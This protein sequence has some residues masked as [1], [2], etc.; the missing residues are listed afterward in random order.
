[1]FTFLTLSVVM[2][3]FGTI[4]SGVYIELQRKKMLCLSDEAL[5][6]AR[7][8]IKQT[9]KYIF[10]VNAGLVLFIITAGVVWVLVNSSSASANESAA[11]VTTGLKDMSLGEGIY[12][13]LAY[14]S[15]AFATG[16]AA[17]AASIGIAVVGSASVGAVSEK[18]EMFG[19]TLVYVGLAEGIAIY[20]LLI[21][22]MILSKI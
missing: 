22:F 6:T 17:I 18:P 19:K 1:M 13:G 10:G 4:L 21:S 9:T 11:A 20:G 12:K 16:I 7:G 14:L 5:N 15:T 2:L 8:K 3:V